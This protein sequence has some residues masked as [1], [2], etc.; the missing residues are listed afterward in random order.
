MI[1]SSEYDRLASAINHGFLVIYPTDTLYAMGASI[2][3][4]QAIEQVFVLKQRPRSLPL[5][6]AVA[7]VEMLKKIAQLTPLAEVLIRSFLPGPMTIVLETTSVSSMIT[8]G[9][10]TVAIRIPDDPIALALL[11]KTGPL[12]VTSAN[13]HTHPTPESIDE[14]RNMFKSK[15]IVAYIDDGIRN[16]S[17]STIVDARYDQPVILREGSLSK[18]QIDAVVT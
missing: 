17:P 1:T 9:K 7:S 14:M 10:S 2:T 8:A 6:V 3:Q 13:I 5:P 11:K 15:A 12:T 16:G 18:K 4:P